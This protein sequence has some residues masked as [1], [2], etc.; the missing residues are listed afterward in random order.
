[1]VT[2]LRLVWLEITDLDRSVPFYREG[3]GLRVEETAPC[4]GQRTA[5]VEAGELE[6]VLAESG[7][8]DPHR[9]AGMRLYLVTHDL[10]H[11]A[12]ALR[13]RGIETAAPTDEPWGARVIEIVDPDGYRLCLVQSRH[14]MMPDEP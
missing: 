7:T 5:C 8:T 6:L 14:Q 10:D 11:Y 4:R 12:A 9:G 13:S 2:G 3:L 1:M